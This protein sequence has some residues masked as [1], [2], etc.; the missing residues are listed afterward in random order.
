MSVKP[1]DKALNQL[2]AKDPIMAAHLRDLTEKVETFE[3]IIRQFVEHSFIWKGGSMASVMAPLG[4]EVK[5][6]E[7]KGL[8]RWELGS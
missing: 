2:A 7:K 1:S 6:V 4:Y 8:F 5:W 3:A